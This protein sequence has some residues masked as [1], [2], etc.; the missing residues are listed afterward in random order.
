M[1]MVRKVIETFAPS[2]MVKDDPELASTITVSAAP[3]TEAPEAPPLE[4][5]QFVVLDASQVPEPPTQ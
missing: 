5:A 2:V 3:G 4:V 1:L